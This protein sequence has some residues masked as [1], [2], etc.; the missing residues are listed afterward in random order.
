MLSTTNVWKLAMTPGRIVH[1]V[2][3]MSQTLAC[4]GR[5][6]QSQT[7]RARLDAHVTCFW[8]IAGVKDPELRWFYFANEMN[9]MPALEMMQAF[10]EDIQ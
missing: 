1:N 4:G 10:R 3:V 8:C 2:D 7:V 5:F 6:A 9:E